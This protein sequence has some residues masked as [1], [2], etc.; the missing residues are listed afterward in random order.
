MVACLDLAAVFFPTSI[1]RGNCAIV[2]GDTSRTPTTPVKPSG[3][4]YIRNIYTGLYV[5]VWVLYNY[6]HAHVHV[7]ALKPLG[8]NTT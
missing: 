3:S 1:K 7:T 2:T 4:A 5:C 8:H 6:I